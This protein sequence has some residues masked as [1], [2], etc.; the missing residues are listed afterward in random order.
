MSKPAP[1]EAISP[2]RPW[3]KSRMVWACGAGVMLLLVCG[4]L[5]RTRFARGEKPPAAEV[6]IQNSV[7]V[8]PFLDLTE[9]MRNESFADG[10]TTQLIGKLS[11]VS[12]LRVPSATAAFSFKNKPSNLDE[13]AKRL[14]V[15]Y[16]L[17]GSVRKTGARLR[18]S[19]RLM[20]IDS[21][22]VLWSE[23]YDRPLA[24]LLMVQDDIAGEVTKALTESFHGQQ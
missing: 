16:V 9:G 5:M 7:A 21:G 3:T 17:D 11:K 14:G 15:S 13:V 19:A 18:V 12:A 6:A 20:R 2:G 4:I 22:D 1:H 23:T 10:M 24:D 8:L